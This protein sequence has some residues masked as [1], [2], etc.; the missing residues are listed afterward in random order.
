MAHWRPRKRHKGLPHEQGIESAAGIGP[1]ADNRL[2]TVGYIHL[3]DSEIAA[4]KESCHS[5]AKQ[6]RTYNAVDNKTNLERTRAE[7]VSDFILEFIANGLD[8]KRVGF[9][10]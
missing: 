10:C 7:E 1:T 5:T 2:K 4:V 8:D 9:G 6:Q 3:V